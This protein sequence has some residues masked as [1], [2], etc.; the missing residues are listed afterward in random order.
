MRLVKRDWALWWVWDD[1]DG[2]H[3]KRAG[4]TDPEHFTYKKR[5]DRDRFINKTEW[6]GRL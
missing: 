3:A 4:V 5:S 2:Y 1:A 6:I